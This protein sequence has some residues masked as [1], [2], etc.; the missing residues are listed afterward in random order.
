MTTEIKR[1]KE[2]IDGHFDKLNSVMNLVVG[3][4]NTIAGRR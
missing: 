4:A 3:A 1:R 2:I